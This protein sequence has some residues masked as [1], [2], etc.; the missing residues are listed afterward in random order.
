MSTGQGFFVCFFWFFFGGGG[1]MFLY[2]GANHSGSSE[3][4]IEFK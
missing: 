1:G 2:Q 3:I 4:N